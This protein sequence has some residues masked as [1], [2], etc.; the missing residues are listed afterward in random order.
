[1]T[2]IEDFS[3]VRITGPIS[4][5]LGQPLM[6]PAPLTEALL[7]AVYRPNI[8][9]RLEGVV[10]PGPPCGRQWKCTHCR[11]ELSHQSRLLLQATPAPLNTVYLICVMSL[12]PPIR[13]HKW[14]PLFCSSRLVPLQ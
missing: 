4:A 7:S 5:A 1:M 6:S 8:S 13:L 11:L 12:P 3:S 2:A 14:F 10:R 9:G